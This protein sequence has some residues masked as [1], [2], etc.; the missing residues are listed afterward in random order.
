MEKRVINL[1]N[2]V[3]G[4]EPRRDLVLFAPVKLDLETD[5]RYHLPHTFLLQYDA[6]ERE[7]FR[8]LFQRELKENASL[9]ELG[10]WFEMSRGLIEKLGMVWRGRPGY[11]WDWHVDPGF[12]EAY[13]VSQREKIID[14]VFGRFREIFGFFHSVEE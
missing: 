1:V 11:D 5:R 7:D 4:C 8:T 3:R 13:T 9:T 6:M 12:L 2:F 10:V 14:E